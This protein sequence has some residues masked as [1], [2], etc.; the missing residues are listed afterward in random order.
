M[1][2]LCWGYIPRPTRRLLWLVPS[3]LL[4]AYRD[5][6]MMETRIYGELN[7]VIAA[8]ALAGVNGWI[9]AHFPAAPRPLL[10]PAVR[11]AGAAVIVTILAFA[12]DR[13]IK[14]CRE[15]EIGW[16]YTLRRNPQ[17]WTAGNNPSSE[18]AGSPGRLPEALA[19][20]EQEL[21]MKPDDAEAN[22]NLANALAGIPGR[23]PEALAYYEE[24]LRIKPDL[25]EAH[26]NLANALA[27]IPGRLPEAVAHYEEALRIKPDLAEAHYNLAHALAEIPGRLPEALAQYDEA[28]RIMP[29][30]AEAQNNVAAIYVKTGRFDEAIAHLELAL[31]LDPALTE[32]RENLKKLRAMRR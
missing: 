19:Y 16:T 2:P 27:G 30:D 6:N 17:S 25:A 3:Y 23:L 18:P 26:N 5:A 24:A 4:I 8:T 14:I 1:I 7:I 15:K 28:L 20:Y 11:W 29:D 32:A 9:R 21:R 31:K 22:N 13:Y 10:R 12:A